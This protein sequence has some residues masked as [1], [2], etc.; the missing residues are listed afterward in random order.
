MPGRAERTACELWGGAIPSPALFLALLF[1]SGPGR[2]G[3]WKGQP[4]E[5][6]PAKGGRGAERINKK[7]A[8]VRIHR[9]N[10]VP[11]GWQHRAP[12]QERVDCDIVYP[13]RA[14]GTGVS[15]PTYPP[16]TR[17]DATLPGLRQA[18]A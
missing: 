1:G 7:K 17:A 5:T 9:G 4:R 12:Y 13:A 11:T 15:P 8:T 2:M 6:P 16:G 3:P 14:M 10:T 18:M